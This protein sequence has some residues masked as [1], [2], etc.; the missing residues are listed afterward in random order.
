MT[1]VTNPDEICY[2]DY[3]YQYGP[4]HTA[5]LGKGRIIKMK[6][7]SNKQHHTY[8]THL[9]F[10]AIHHFFF[11]VLFFWAHTVEALLWRAFIFI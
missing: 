1:Q 4:I 5:E 10:H 6:D 7:N 8:P 11:L 2:T 3:S 9:S